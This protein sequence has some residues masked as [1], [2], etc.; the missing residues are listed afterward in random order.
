MCIMHEMYLWYTVLKYLKYT[1]WGSGVVGIATFS[2]Y[3][4]ASERKLEN[5]EENGEYREK[6]T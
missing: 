2:M 6:C 4:H 1:V 5:Q 3:Q